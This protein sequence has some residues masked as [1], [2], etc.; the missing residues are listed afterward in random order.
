[1][2]FLI[3][4]IFVHFYTIKPFHVGDF[5]LKYKRKT[6]ILGGARHPLISDMLSVVSVPDAH[7][8][9]TH[10]FLTHVL[11]VCTSSWRIRS[12]YTSVPDARM[13]SMLYRD[14]FNFR[15]CSQCTNQFL[16]RML[17]VRTAVPNPYAK[18]KFS[19]WP[20]CSKYASIPDPY[21]QWTHQFLTRMRK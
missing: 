5:G 21:A 3:A 4:R 6:L 19:S 15:M 8:Q 20:I 11:S 14:L 2:R 16:T 10:Q 1:V 12:G 9:C 7:P 13:L 18:R 17:S